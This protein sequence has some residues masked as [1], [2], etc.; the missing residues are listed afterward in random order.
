[1]KHLPFTG[2]ALLCFAGTASAESAY[3][4][5]LANSAGTEPLG[6]MATCATVPTIAPN[7]VTDLRVPTDTAFTLDVRGQAPRLPNSL[8]TFTLNAWS[9]QT[10]VAVTNQVSIFAMDFAPDGTTLYGATGATAAA[11]PSTLGTVNTTTAV[12]TPIG[13]ITG[14]TVGDSATGL[15]IHPRTGVAYFAAAGGTPA[16]SRLYSMNLATAALTLIG[17]ITAPTDATGTIMIDIAINCEGQLFAH[18]ISD[19][20]LY[21]VN[22]TTGAGTFIGGHG[23]A[24]NFAQG[25]DFDNSDGTLYADIYTGTGT[26]RFGTFNLATG[27]FATLVQDNPLGEFELAIPTACPV[28][29]DELFADGFEDAVPKL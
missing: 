15:A 29:A 20:A 8:Y 14:M 9:T 21:S 24:S 17:Q 26:N 23:L 6:Y 2:L 18:N 27:A 13:A 1:M 10:L 4:A 3:C 12:F 22:T 28:L 5:S 19:D 7:I 25:M 16:T 11:N